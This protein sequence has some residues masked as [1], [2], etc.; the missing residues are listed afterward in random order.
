M[1]SYK[2]LKLSTGDELLSIVHSNKKD[3]ILKLESPMRMVFIGAPNSILDSFDNT[4]QMAL[5]KWAPCT[6]D[7]Y[8]EIHEKW[9]VCMTDISDEMQE[10]Y[11][12][13]REEQAGSVVTTRGPKQD[14]DQQIETELNQED[15]IF[16]E[17]S[18][19]DAISPQN[20]LEQLKDLA[21]IRSG[22][23]TIH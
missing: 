14:D 13:S 16:D 4:C 2:Y 17:L 9:V 5:G 18:Q 3:E 1:K 19:W 23:V 11:N 6:E 12:Q 10:F 20:F 22:K 15:K 21:R 8:V 7:I